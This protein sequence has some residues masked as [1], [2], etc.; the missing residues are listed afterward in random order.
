M[1][2]KLSLA[3]KLILITSTLLTSVVLFVSYKSAHLFEQVSIDKEESI[4]ISMSELKA[5]TLEILVKNYINNISNIVRENL[6]SDNPNG[7][8]TSDEVLFI[9]T[10]SIDKNSRELFLSGIDDRGDAKK[11]SFLFKLQKLNKY[12]HQL[13]TGKIFIFNSSYDER[14]LNFILGFPLTSLDNKTHVVVYAQIKSDQILKIFKSNNKQSYFLLDEEGEYIASS[15]ENQLLINDNS[16][17]FILKRFNGSAVKSQQQYLYDNNK[18][19]WLVTTSRLSFGMYLFSKVSRDTIIAPSEFIKKNSYY[20]LGLVL[21]SV[22]ILVFI[23]SEH[24]S[25]PIEL[26]TT[27]AQRIGQGD[28]SVVATEKIQSSD[29]V[30]DLAKSF[31]FMVGGLKERDKMKTLFSKFHGTAVTKELLDNEIKLGG[32]RKEMTVFFSDIRGFT[33]FSEGRTPEEV[34]SMLNEYF[35]VMVHIINQ[36]G[37]VVDKFIGDAIMAVWG[38]PHQT[39]DDANNA[40]LAS[41]EMRMALN[42]LNENRIERGLTPI[43]IGM[44]LHSGEAISGQIGSSERME[45]TVIGDAVNTAS[46]I[47]G[48]TKSFGTDLLLSKEV[49][50]KLDNK[51]LLVKAGEAKVQGKSENLVLYMVRGIIENGVEN[52]LS[53]P[54]SS[55]EAVEDKKSKVAT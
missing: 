30:G 20:L 29:E 23:F 55:Y 37:G 46:R 5:Y 10:V 35:E 17:K 42:R 39:P 51:F 24:I 16:A 45:F 22:I 6:V 36:R 54:Y 34:V 43:K 2:L 47:E 52:I 14:N 15:D 12:K 33:D 41:L 49:V 31:D 13:T 26:L 9:K 4:N 32:K 38:V 48:S 8:L 11:K 28:L 7:I 53:T 18:N 3:F 44:G 1:K 25:R 21:S 50:A 27:Y 19:N 40:V